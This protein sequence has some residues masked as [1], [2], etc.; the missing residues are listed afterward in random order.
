M[1]HYSPSQ[2]R[3]YQ[4]CGQQYAYRYVKKLHE[5]TKE[6]LVIGRA[7]D[8]AIN[9]IHTN[10]MEPSLPA[11][12]EVFLFQTIES[13]RF[14]HGD[15]LKAEEWDSIDEMATR[16]VE[17]DVFEQYKSMIDY[18]VRAI[19]HD[20]VLRVHGLDRKIIGI[21][22]CIA[23]R[24]VFGQKEHY[25]SA[26]IL[27][28]KTAARSV[29]PKPSYS[30]RFQMSVY[31]LAWMC[32]QGT[33]IIPQCEVRVLVKKKKPE[34]QVQAIPITENDLAHVLEVARMHE[35]S[36]KAQY[37]P[38]NRDSKF[39]SQKNCSYFERCHEEHGGRLTDV[40]AQCIRG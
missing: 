28:V 17:H 16:F 27:D 9:S 32:M 7:V 33:E 23:E 26:L 19:Q 5:K 13:E 14:T 4:D 40:L 8:E 11:K 18:K 25:E 10:V 38:I 34:W 1:D 3:K 29:S 31:A 39:C 35:R 21:A 6:A 24:S 22:D 2:F 12:P 36:V 30:Y 20:M 15:E 37:F